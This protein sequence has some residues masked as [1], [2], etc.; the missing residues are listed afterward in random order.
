MIVSFEHNFLIV[1]ANTMKG[2]DQKKRKRLPCGLLK[3]ME[4]LLLYLGMLDQSLNGCAKRKA[5]N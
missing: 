2:L 4:R 1:R 5:L 3:L